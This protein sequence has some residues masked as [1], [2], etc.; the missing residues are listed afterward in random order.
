MT[1]P[2]TGIVSEEEFNKNK[3]KNHWY[4]AANKIPMP[5]NVAKSQWT[6]PTYYAR[7][8]K[9]RYSKDFPN[10]INP[11]YKLIEKHYDPKTHV[12]IKETFTPLSG[13]TTI[14]RPVGTYIS[15]MSTDFE[16]SEGDKDFGGG[17]G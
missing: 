6:D 14:I 16:V 13:P 9:V 2:P 8:Y 10:N 12:L 15:V 17:G 1:I 4:I 7:S 3:P 11:P 5:M